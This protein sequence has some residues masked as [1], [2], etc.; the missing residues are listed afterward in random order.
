[1]DMMMRVLKSKVRGLEFEGQKIRRKIEKSSGLER[2]NHWTRKRE[3]GYYTRAHLLAY[4]FLR[5]VPYNQMERKSNCVVDLQLLLQIIHEHVPTYKR[6]EWTIE[7]IESLIWGPAPEATPEP[8]VS[9]P[10]VTP[11]VPAPIV[12]RSLISRVKSVLRPS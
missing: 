9:P 11:E 7:R 2:F 6:R 10:Q 3:L 12:S 4:G 8:V 5:G 1:M